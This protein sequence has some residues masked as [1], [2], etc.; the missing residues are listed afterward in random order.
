MDGH[1]TDGSCGNPPVL[2]G[3]SNDDC[4]DGA[5]PAFASTRCAN[6]FADN[7][8]ANGTRRTRKRELEDGAISALLELNNAG[9]E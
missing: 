6:N 1:C 9:N 5:H 3:G 4:C 2:S 8:A 7:G